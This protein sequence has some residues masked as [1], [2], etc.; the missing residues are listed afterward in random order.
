MILGLSHIV[1]ASTDLIRD[2]QHLEQLGW[3]TTFEQRGIATH[4]GKRAWM[5]TDS[6]E[7]GLV[8]MQPPSGTPVELIH[9]ANELA[10]ASPSPLQIVLPTSEVTLSQASTCATALP[11]VIEQSVPQL[12]CPLWLSQAA[13]VPSLIIHHVT[14]MAAAQRFWQEGLG[15]KP[16][17]HPAE[18]VGA[19]QMELR[20][21]MA[22]WRATLLLLPRHGPAVPHLLDGPGYRCLSF[23]VSDLQQDRQRLLRAGAR[24]CTGPFQLEVNAKSLALELLAG[25]DG[26]M[27]EIFQT[28]S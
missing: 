21:L 16:S 24:E 10:D 22:Q 20:S 23:V 7:Q 18:I 11:G 28:A 8:F 19:V 1:L 12:T 4:P 2:R 9:Y 15:F 3:A 25:P 14:D 13:P 17:I 26:A 5:S 27:I 6:N